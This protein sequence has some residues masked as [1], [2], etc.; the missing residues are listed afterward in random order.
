[1]NRV[2]I[3]LAAGALALTACKPS[4]KTSIPEA[5][6]AGPQ[7]VAPTAGSST[8]VT[9]TRRVPAAGSKAKQKRDVGLQLTSG[10]EV[11]RHSS[12]DIVTYEVKQ[13]DS[14]RV[15]QAKIDVEDLYEA[16]QQG[17][18]AEAKAINPLSGK[19]FVVTRKSDGRL[20]ALD[21]TG[22]TAS[23]E[24]L[25]LIEQQYGKLFEKDE[26]GAFVPARPMTVGEKLKPTRAALLEMMQIADD[27]ADTS[28]EDVDFTLANAE[29]DRAKFDVAMTMT[30]AMGGGFRL[31]ARLLGKVSLDTSTARLRTLELAGPVVVLDVKGAE[32]GSG[33][34][35]AHVE[36]VTL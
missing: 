28:I 34:F 22:A 20:F 30:W 31:R 2:P 35:K 36:V 21:S 24:Q 12:H 1:V 11:M 3:L 16:N 9:L 19:G 17:D 6:S 10:G 15:T 5:A 7:T 25:G 13:V 32:T 23:D 33:G 26:I 14:N 4:S 18:E 27:D 29:T 8:A